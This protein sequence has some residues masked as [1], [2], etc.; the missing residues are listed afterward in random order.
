[1]PTIDSLLSGGQLI[2]ESVCPFRK[3][4][5]IS[6]SLTRSGMRIGIFSF[7]KKNR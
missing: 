7:E 1:M 3:A 2:D 6:V 5:M 4:S